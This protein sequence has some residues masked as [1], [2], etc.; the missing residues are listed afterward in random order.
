VHCGSTSGPSVS[1]S[2]TVP[3]TTTVTPPGLAREAASACFSVAA[4]VAV[5][6]FPAASHAVGVVTVRVCWSGSRASCHVELGRL[7]LTISV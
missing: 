2:T 4:E 1:V 6:V 5:M 7:P 3:S